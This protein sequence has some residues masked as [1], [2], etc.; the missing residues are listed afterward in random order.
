MTSGA[1]ELVGAFRPDAIG[2]PMLPMVPV[3]SSPPVFL[4]RVGRTVPLSGGRR[5]M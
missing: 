2:E 5:L 4:E 1:S 3:S